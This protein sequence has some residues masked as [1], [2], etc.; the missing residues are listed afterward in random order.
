LRYEGKSGRE[1]G[2]EEGHSALS[3][4]LR[5]EEMEEAVT[6][7]LIGGGGGGGRF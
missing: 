3:K 7:S 5:A 4:K 2:G 1:L 6:S